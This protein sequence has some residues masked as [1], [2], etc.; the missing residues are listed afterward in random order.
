MAKKSKHLKKSPSVN[1]LL[2]HLSAEVIEIQKKLD[3]K[4]YTDLVQFEKDIAHLP[5]MQKQFLLAA[6]P[7]HQQ[8]S[9]Y[10]INTRI[11]WQKEKSVAAGIG[12]NLLN[13]SAD[14]RYQ[15]KTSGDS[16]INIE[17][18]QIPSPIHNHLKQKS[19]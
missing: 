13:L 15:R 7:A 1:Q 11:S 4:F 19:K 16:F 10:E 6:F 5:D 12:I 2:L 14:L 17:V 3:Q 8:V 18:E 9:K